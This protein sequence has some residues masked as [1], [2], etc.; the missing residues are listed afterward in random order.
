MQRLPLDTF[1]WTSLSDRISPPR[2]D[3]ASV[4]LNATVSPRPE[5]PTLQADSSTDALHL[6]CVARSSIPIDGGV[7]TQ[8]A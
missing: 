5:A 8:K 7:Q 6:A 3:G 4:R 1:S 2:G